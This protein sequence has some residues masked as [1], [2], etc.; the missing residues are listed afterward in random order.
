MCL[1]GGGDLWPGGPVGT[2][3]AGVQ[4]QAGQAQLPWLGPA[5]PGGSSGSLETV[6]IK[7]D[8]FAKNSDQ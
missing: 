6:V 5:H 4:A 7:I 8:W 3:Q 2:D 1:K